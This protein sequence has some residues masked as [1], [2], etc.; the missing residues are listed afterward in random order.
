MEDIKFHQC[1]RLARFENDRTIRSRDLS[2]SPFFLSANKSLFQLALT[3][4]CLS[5]GQSFIP[6]DGEFDLMSYRLQATV[7]PLIWV[8]AVVEPHSHSRIEYM[9]KAKSQV[10]IFMFYIKSKS[11]FHFSHSICSSKVAPSRTMWRLS[12]LSHLM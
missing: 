10:S 8:E 11:P 7:K 3:F 12:F 4:F 1:V 6:P 5:L 9:I 2:V